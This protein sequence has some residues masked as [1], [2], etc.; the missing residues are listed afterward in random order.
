MTLNAI[1]PAPV[2]YETPCCITTAYG[3]SGMICVSG[4]LNDYGDDFIFEEEF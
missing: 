3:S 2:R 4:N 1:N